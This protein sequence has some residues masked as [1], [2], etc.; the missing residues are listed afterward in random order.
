MAK[1]LLRPKAARERVGV[2][3]TK[4]DADYVDHGREG[5]RNIPGTDIPRVRPVPLGP[6]AIAFIEA[7]IDELIERLARRR[8]TH[9]ET[10]PRTLAGRAAVARTSPPARHSASQKGGN[11]K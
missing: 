10:L 1:Q 9:P 5:E 11:P 4:F 7:E 6:R 3:R 8:D 2:K